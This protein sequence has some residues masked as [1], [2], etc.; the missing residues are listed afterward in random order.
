ML[1]IITTH[2]T[3]YYHSNLRHL[4]SPSLLT[5]IFTPLNRP[6]PPQLSDIQPHPFVPRKKDKQRHNT[7]LDARGHQ[8]EHK[9]FDFISSKIAGSIVRKRNHPVRDPTDI[10]P[11]LSLMYDEALHVDELRINLQC[12][13]LDPQIESV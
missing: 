6:H 13:H 12:D 3:F 8:D 9:Y 5:V 2:I 1:Y 7:F 11:S 10:E 4:V